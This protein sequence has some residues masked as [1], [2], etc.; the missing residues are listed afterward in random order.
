MSIAKSI[1]WLYANYAILQGKYSGKYVAIFK[2]DIIAT[3]DS[4]EEVDSKA[5]LIIP[6]DK[7]YLIE[8]IERG[9]LYAYNITVS[10]NSPR[11]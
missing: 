7:E 9:D 5:K 8:F 2:E 3:G 11:S 6:K 4:F 1:Q 10:S